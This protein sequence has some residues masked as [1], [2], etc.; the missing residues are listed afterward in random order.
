MVSAQQHG[1][2]EASGQP[3]CVAGSC[4]GC[5]VEIYSPHALEA[6]GIGDLLREAG[7]VTPRLTT[8]LDPDLATD[9]GAPPDVILLDGCLCGDDMSALREL[10]AGGRPVIVLVGPERDGAFIHGV[11]RAGAKG[12][13]SCDEEPQR[14]A[15][16]VRMVFQGAVV[17]SSDAAV[18]MAGAPTSGSSQSTTD[19]LTTRQQQVAVMVAQG[20]S[21]KEIGDA[22]C[23]S[24]HTVKIQLGQIL[25]KLNLCNRQQLAAYV[26][27]QGMLDDI[28][29]V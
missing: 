23:I 26:A 11:M 29:L 25:E 17:I 2:D 20:A 18:R 27:E 24:E 22:L 3:T 10:A 6:E 7:C 13:L 21:N 4:P 19:G 15:T 1:S 16:C 12:C 5:S 14:F 8:T 9:D 28:Q